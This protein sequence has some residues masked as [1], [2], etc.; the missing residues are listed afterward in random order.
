MN[1]P[2]KDFHQRALTIH[3][4]VFGSDHP[5]VAKSLSNLGNVCNNLGQY[6]EAKDFH[7]RALVIHQAVYGSDH[8][9]VAN[10]LKRLELVCHDLDK[11]RHSSCLLL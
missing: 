6:E 2:C 11:Q 3:Q 9:R 8:P 5:N 4:A 1:K 10:C 7:Q